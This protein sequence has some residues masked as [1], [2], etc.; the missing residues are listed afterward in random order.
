[1]KIIKTVEL[2]QFD[3]GPEKDIQENDRDRGQEVGDRQDINSK[4]GNVV[5]QY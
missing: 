4:K 2:I 1:M 5:S 3:L